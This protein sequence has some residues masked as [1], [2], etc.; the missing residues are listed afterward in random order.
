MWGILKFLLNDIKT[1]IYSNLKRIFLVVRVDIRYPFYKVWL[2]LCGLDCEENEREKERKSRHEH[3]CCI[4]LTEQLTIYWG[5][6]KEGQPT[7][8]SA[9]L[10]TGDMYRRFS[11]RA[12]VGLM[13][14]SLEWRNDKTSDTRWLYLVLS[15]FNKNVSQI[16]LMKGMCCTKFMSLDKK[17]NTWLIWSKYF[18]RLLFGFF[19]T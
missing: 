15:T 9:T 16:Y 2:V 4:T 14:S 13:L 11:I 8:L 19:R 12:C 3:W 1:P 10:E 5:N 17:L 7:V 6:S 18:W